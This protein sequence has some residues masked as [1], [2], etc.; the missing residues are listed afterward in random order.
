MT[1]EFPPEGTWLTPEPLCPPRISRIWRPGWP[2]FLPPLPLPSSP[3]SSPP[4]PLPFPPPMGSRLPPLL[5]KHP[6]PPPPPLDQEVCGWPA[7]LA[8]PLLQL[9][10]G[11]TTLTARLPSWL[12]LPHPSTAL[13]PEVKRGTLTVPRAPHAHHASHA[14]RAPHAPHAPPTP[15]SF[16]SNYF[17]AP[18]PL[19][20]TTLYW[21]NNPLFV[22]HPLSPPPPSVPHTALHVKDQQ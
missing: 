19:P 6:F 2:P 13:D 21:F 11:L 12:T 3:S 15:C 8:G 14:P 9:Q 17:S 7:P 22:L 10:A 1:P 5:P 4:F 18:S 20:S 16:V